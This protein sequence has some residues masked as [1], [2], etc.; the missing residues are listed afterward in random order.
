[1]ILEAGAAYGCSDSGAGERVLVEFVS[2]NPTG[3]LH[4]GHGRGAAYGDCV[5]RL[6]AATGYDVA[7]EYYVN[8]AGRQMDILALS[9]YLRYLEAGGAALRYPEAAYRGDYIK[10]S[11]QRLRARDGARYEQPIDTLFADI[12]ADAE[13][14]GDKDAHVDALIERSRTLLGEATFRALLQFIL[15]EQLAD[16]EGD[17]SHFGVHFE[18]W[19]SERSLVTEDL[20]DR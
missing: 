7:R 12:P 15:D 1:D 8:D 19:F 2:A 11:A 18:R 3:P 13:Q 17:L 9:L 4:V 16:I 14:S 6:L 20:M 10:D 5:A